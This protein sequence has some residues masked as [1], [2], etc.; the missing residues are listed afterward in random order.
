MTPNLSYVATRFDLTQRKPPAVADFGL[1]V[2]HDH[3]VNPV[4]DT[5]RACF[6]ARPLYQPLYQRVASSC[7]SARIQG[8]GTGW[9]DKDVAG[10]LGVEVAQY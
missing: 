4:R 10:A 8:R 7:C 2:E 6:F 3:V 5:L 9:L 1:E